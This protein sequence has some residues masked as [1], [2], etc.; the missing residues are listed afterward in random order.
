MADAVPLRIT[1][2]P[3]GYWDA[4]RDG[5]TKP[6]WIEPE[7]IPRFG[8]PSYRS[9]VCDLAQDVSDMP[10]STYACARALGVPIVAIPIFT[11]QFNVPLSP[12][13][14]NVHSGMK[15]PRDLEGMRVGLS[16]FGITPTTLVGGLL[17]SELGIDTDQITW[18]ATEECYVAQYQPPPNVEIAPRVKNLVDMLEAGEIDASLSVDPQGEHLPI[19][20]NCRALLLQYFRRTGIYPI[21]HIITVKEEVVKAHPWVGE[22]LF[23]AFA[24]SKDLYMESLGKLPTHGDV[25][26]RD[27]EQRLIYNRKIVED[28]FPH[29]LPRNRKN[30]E[31]MIQLYV[32]QRII[33][34]PMD[35]D[36]LF[37]PGTLDLE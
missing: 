32:D 4:L 23:R 12:I 31:A 29:G 13:R 9:M 21:A 22:S 27:L 20:V 2:S 16:S 1:M 6:R 7:F 36:S 28:P 17:R 24:A 35:V 37:A 10:M 19:L 34:A 15:E 3:N 30:V 33:S 11:F 8:P 25:E 18:V 14:Y 5:R 26:R